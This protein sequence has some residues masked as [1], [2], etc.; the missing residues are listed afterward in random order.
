MKRYAKHQVTAKAIS[1]YPTP[2]T[3]SQPCRQNG[4]AT[5]FRS[6]TALFAWQRP[7]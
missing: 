5:R 2:N 6:I 4:A 3:R 1:E 7:N